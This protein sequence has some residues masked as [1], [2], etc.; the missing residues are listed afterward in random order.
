MIL[1]TGGDCGGGDC[2]G[3][4]S[5]G[6]DSNSIWCIYGWAVMYFYCTGGSAG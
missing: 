1:I 6:G 2:G 5:G 4:D 3:G